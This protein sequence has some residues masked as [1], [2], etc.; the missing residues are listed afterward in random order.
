[1]FTYHLHAFQVVEG[2]KQLGKCYMETSPT[3]AATLVSSQVVGTHRQSLGAP[4]ACS[5]SV[6]KPHHVSSDT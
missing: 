1:M 6:F 4:G 3:G 2:K 5:A